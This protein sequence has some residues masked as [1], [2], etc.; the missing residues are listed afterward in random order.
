MESAAASQT[1]A[2]MLTSQNYIIKRKLILSFNL[3]S[4]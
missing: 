3:R 1:F 4:T 2:L